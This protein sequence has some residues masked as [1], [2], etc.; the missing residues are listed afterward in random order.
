MK[1]CIV[2]AISCCI[3]KMRNV[4]DRCRENQDT[5]F[6][7]SNFFLKIVRYLWDNVEKYCRAR[8]ATVDDIVW[9]MCFACCITKA[10]DKHS[11]YVI[12][13]ALLRHRWLL[14][15]ASLLGLD[16]HCLCCL[17]LVWHGKWEI[18]CQMITLELYPGIL[19]I[20]HSVRL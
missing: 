20:G 7:F 10:T 6:V 9:G 4:S 15:C 16:V 18:W 3:L 13:I 8:Q 17:T 11:K 5:R 1:T 19:A 12:F 14:E 2:I